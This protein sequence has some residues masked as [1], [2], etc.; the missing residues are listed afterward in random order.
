MKRCLDVLR[1]AENRRADLCIFPELTIT[2]YPP[3]DLLLK[4]GFVAD[5]LSA[6][7]EVVAAT[8]ECVAVVGYVAPNES[9]NSRPKSSNPGHPMLTNA[10]AVCA[11]GEMVGTHQ[12]RLLPNYGVFDEERWF[13]PGSG[14][15]G[16]YEIAGGW[17][18]V[19]IC[20]DIWSPLGPA[21]AL[22]R[23]GADV[24]ANINSSPYSRNRRD[25][26]ISMLTER[27][28]DAGCAIA[29]VNQVGGQDELVF[30]GASL[31]IDKDGTMVAAGK[32]FDEDFLVVDFPLPQPIETVGDTRSSEPER[33]TS[34]GHVHT[35]HGSYHD[36]GRGPSPWQPSVFQIHFRRAQKSMRLSCWEPVTTC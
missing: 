21:P 28:R 32:Q 27:A 18:G 36:T 8:A 19:T 9:T 26:R 16:L 3:E 35:H 4:P 10:A 23:A 2:G 5:N 34:R 17:V 30:D 7:D 22:G 1:E 12:K 31:V 20:E 29:Y 15:L 11:N 13:E 33:A 24:I 6:L 25:A 14:P